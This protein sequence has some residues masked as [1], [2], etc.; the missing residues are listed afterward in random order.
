MPGLPRRGLLG[1]GGTL[2]AAPALG[3]APAVPPLVVMEVTGAGLVLPLLQDFANAHPG[4]VSG[5]ALE[6]IDVDVI[7]EDL[8]DAVAAG[9][10]GIDLV[11]AGDAGIVAGIQ[12][13][14][15]QPATDWAL[16]GLPPL[17]GLVTPAAMSLWRGFAG[18]ALPILAGPNGPLLGWRP[19]R[20]DR[21]P[22]SPAELLDW[23]REN[24]G[25]FLYGR[26][27]LVTS[28]RLFLRALPWL[29]GDSDPMRPATGW[30]RSWSWLAELDRHIDY[31]PTSLVAATAEFRDDGC[32]M[33]VLSVA[34]DLEMRASGLLPENL[35]ASAFADQAW[36][37]AGISA[38]IPRD[39]PAD[40][41]PVVAALLRHLL[42]PAVQAN[43]LFG[44]GA[45]AGARLRLDVEG[46]AQG[47]L[48]ADLRAA[49]SLPLGTRLMLPRP[50][51]L[52]PQAPLLQPLG[53]ED[54]LEAGRIWDARIGAAHGLP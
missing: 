19:G 30:D 22:R 10:S 20:V 5:V 41:R 38:A 3:Q 24:P 23:A 52:A 28:S 29:L 47:T 35:G 1:L 17:D 36:A 53:W 45:D 11:F 46:A 32:D 9:Q 37:L 12:A 7:T 44:R 39:L 8:A 16:D 2:L 25:R 34:G 26:P 33:L 50:G 14:A 15:W 49:G 54:A 4:L 48:H 13:E 18:L 6:Q 42:S 40:R 21:M 51:L 43:M 31:Y 27:P